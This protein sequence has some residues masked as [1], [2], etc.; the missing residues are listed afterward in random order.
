[1]SKEPLKLLIARASV[2]FADG[3]ALVGG[4]R[5]LTRAEL[6]RL[7]RRGVL[8]SELRR[9]DSGTLVRVWTWRGE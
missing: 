2:A 4:M 8:R 7:E 1:M 6:R 3:K 9:L 5:G